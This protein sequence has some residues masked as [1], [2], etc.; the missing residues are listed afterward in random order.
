MACEDLAATIANMQQALIVDDNAIQAAQNILA[1]AQ[2]TKY[3]HQMALW[4]AQYN[5]ILE[6]CDGGGSGSGYGRAPAAAELVIGDA[7]PGSAIG[8]TPESEQRRR[9]PVRTPEELLVITAIPE[10]YALHKRCAAVTVV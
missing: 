10:L 8:I 6:G 5:F 7:S 2:M 9:M 1:V 4:Y 3:A